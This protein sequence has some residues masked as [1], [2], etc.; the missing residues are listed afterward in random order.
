VKQAEAGI[1]QENAHVLSNSQIMPGVSLLRFE[2]KY[3]AA[4]AKPGQYLMV[5]CGENAVLPRPLSVHFVEES[6]VGLLFRTVGKGTSWLSQR[7][8]GDTIS[9]FGPLGN[10]FEIAEEA[11][12]LLL[13]GGG[14]GVSPLYFLAQ[15]ARNKGL[16]VILIT[17]AQN[18][19]GLYPEQ[20]LPVGIQIVFATEDGSLGHHG[21]VTDLN[22]KQ[23]SIVDQIFACGPLN[24]Y[25]TMSKMPV[26]KKIP[27]QI[28]LEVRM[29]C[30]RGL[31]YG[32]TL[33]TKSGLKKVCE[34]GPVF[35][36]D[37]ILWD[38]LSHM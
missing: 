38:E 12:T 15:T 16:T 36:L 30:G 23:L 18:K 11:K 28:S 24:M 20:L 35:K 29:G 6:A 10:K 21:L 25:K 17:G 8:P 22:A 34:D 1:K 37:D 27:V 31:C 7:R 2:S 19:D 4:Q 32:C 9:V 3:L 14:I 5:S 13:V 33:K 26:F